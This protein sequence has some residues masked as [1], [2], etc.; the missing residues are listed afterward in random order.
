[1]GYLDRIEECNTF[2]PSRYLPFWVGAE[3]V[4]RVSREFAERLEAFA[5]VFDVT[6]GRVALR[7]HLQSFDRRTSAMEGVLMALRAEGVVK[8][9]RDE[10]YAVSGP[11]AKPLMTMERAGVPLFGVRAYGVHLNGFVRQGDGHEMWVARRGRDKPTYP[12]AL[13]NIAAGGIGYGIGVRDSLVRE[14]ADEAGIPPAL[15]ARAVPVGA[16]TY[17][18]ETDE[19]LRFDVIFAFDLELP[20][21]FV[22]QNADGEVAAFD[23][24]PIERVAQTVRETREFKFNCNLVIIDFLVRFGLIAHEDADYLDIVKGLRQ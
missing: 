2:D 15:S 3:R 9:W 22:P 12:S 8:G 1:M 6:P 20:A 13:D 23:L 17:C 14:A 16:I 19:G 24:W 11:G 21:D 4:G 18:C 7:L 10:S 5:D